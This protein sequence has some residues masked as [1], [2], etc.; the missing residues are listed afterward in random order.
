MTSTLDPT[1]TMPP[2]PG[3]RELVAIGA[4]GATEGGSR[5]RRLG[6]TGRGILTMLAS[7]VSNS[8]G[9]GIG[10]TAFPA[11]GPAGVV[12]VRQIVAAAV[13]LPVA[14]PPLRRLTW[15]QWWPVLLLAAVFALMNLALYTAIDRIGL[16]LAVT[17]EFLGPL[18]IALLA[19]RTRRDLVLALAA[20]AG[21]Y[22]L[23]QPGPTSDLVGIAIALVAATCW[24]GYILLNRLVGRRLTGLQA[25]AIAT[26]VSALAYLPVL[27]WLAADGR[28]TVAAA[29][30]AITAGVLS[31]VVPYAADLTALR[32]VPPRF[33]ALFMSIHPVIAALVGV[34]LLRQIPA[35]SQWLGILVVVAVNALA[36]GRPHR[37]AGS[38]PR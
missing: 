21:V 7:G 17:L 30:A 19:S 11:I 13:L 26:S 35:A 28:F 31:S 4:P 3:E 9:A 2:A 6:P 25:P 8:T 34:V 10:T 36:V 33:F 29:M 37:R 16:A 32:L 14:R 27:V 20:A 24:A 23:V 18:A 12:A 22:V 1:P 38:A 5:A 15:P